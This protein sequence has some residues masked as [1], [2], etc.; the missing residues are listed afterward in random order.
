MPRPLPIWRLTGLEGVLV[1][2]RE[3]GRKKQDG[4]REREK[5]LSR[6][7][8]TNTFRQSIN[9]ASNESSSNESSR[10]KNNEIEKK[11]NLGAKSS[12]PLFRIED[13]YLCARSY[14]LNRLTFSRIRADL[15]H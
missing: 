12:P 6:S 10:R 5:R 4:K 9:T 11:K 15:A 7:C 13:D 8:I 2:E 1:G 3:E 14:K